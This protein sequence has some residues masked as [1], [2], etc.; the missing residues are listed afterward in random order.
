VETPWIYQLFCKNLCGQT[1]TLFVS[2]SDTVAVLKGLIQEREGIP[3]DQQRVI[4][5]G[6]QLE[7]GRTLL[8]YAIKPESTM[9]LACRLGGDIGH[10]GAHSDAVGTQFLKGDAASPDDSRAIMRALGVTAHTMFE[11]CSDAGLDPKP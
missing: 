2:S 9:H 7:N 4:F 5:A 10:W 3:V 6:R 11:S 8:D 1:L